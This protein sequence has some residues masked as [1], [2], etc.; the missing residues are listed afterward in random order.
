LTN[1]IWLVLA[2]AWLL[3]FQDKPRFEAGQHEEQ[4]RFARSFSISSALL[5][6]VLTAREVDQN[7]PA[8]WANYVAC[9][10]QVLI[11]LLYAW[12]RSATEESG[13][14]MN[15]VQFA[16]ITATFL[17]GASFGLTEYVQKL[18]KHGPDSKSS[19][20]A[21]QYLYSAIGLYVLWAACIV[22]WAKHLMTLIRVEIPQPA[23]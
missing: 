16:L 18:P 12:A 23:K 1:S 4:L 13:A 21:F 22:R 9:F 17:V 3:S 20:V 8:F 7:L 10:L 2:V 6:M 19:T 15:F 11:F 5:A 14:A